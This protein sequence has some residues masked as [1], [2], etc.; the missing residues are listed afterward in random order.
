M[1]FLQLGILLLS[2]CL[3]VSCGQEEGG[4]NEIERIDEYFDVYGLLNRNEEVLRGMEVSL[5]KNASFGGEQEENL[6]QLDS[7]AL[8][9]ELDVFRQAGINK[10]VLSGRYS[11]VVTEEDGLKVI[12]YEADD[13]GDLDIN[14]LKIYL[15]KQENEVEQLEALFS[16]RNVLYKS[17]RLLKVTYG[18]VAGRQLPLSYTIDGVQKMI[19][20]EQEE[21]RIEGEFL[22]KN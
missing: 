13:E 20:S 4:E 19:F 17:T 22:Y 15:D 6:I 9:R 7:T 14:Y 3:L 10:P 11:E 8:A 21:Y 5:L 16:D 12:A 2:T 18:E 1:R